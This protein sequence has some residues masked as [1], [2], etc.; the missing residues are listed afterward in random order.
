MNRW[1]PI[2]VSVCLLFGPSI[3]AQTSS[4]SESYN[5]LVRLDE[6]GLSHSSLIKAIEIWQDPDF[7]SLESGLSLAEKL[8]VFLIS[9]KAARILTEAVMVQGAEAVMAP[10]EDLDH[11]R[12]PREARIALSEIAIQYAWYQIE[13]GDR[14]DVE[15]S[16]RES[17]RYSIG[18]NRSREARVSMLKYALS[19]KGLHKEELFDLCNTIDARF[20]KFECLYDLSQLFRVMEDTASEIEILS[21]IIGIHEDSSCISH[22]SILTH[23]IHRIS[24]LRG[25]IVQLTNIECPVIRA[26]KLEALE[27][28][29]DVALYAA[30]IIIES[31]GEKLRGSSFVERSLRASEESDDFLDAGY[32][33]NIRRALRILEE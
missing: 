19:K 2:A 18:K 9:Y 29:E 17:Q 15:K 12:L 26:K 28:F 25:R 22:V 16:I 32:I 27:P 13:Y 24:I 33:L 20:E 4:I 11:E 14:H 31:K 30:P 10:L 5:E 6:I 7:S 21:D 23:A 3:Q 8:D 1:L